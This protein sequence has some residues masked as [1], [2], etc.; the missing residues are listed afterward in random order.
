MTIYGGFGRLDVMRRPSFHFDKT[1]DV[2]IPAD[3]IEF[4]A[5]MRGA[6]VAGDDRIAPPAQVKIR[7]SFAAPA[8]TLLRGHVLRRERSCCQPV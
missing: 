8:G 6:V 2:P 1:Q 7:V 4:A 5:I 3:K